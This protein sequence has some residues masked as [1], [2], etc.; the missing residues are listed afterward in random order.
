MSFLPH[1]MTREERRRRPEVQPL[2]ARDVPEISEPEPPGNLLAFQVV[3]GVRLGSYDDQTCCPRRGSRWQWRSR[4]RR[5]PKVS[6]KPCSD[7]DP[8]H[9]RTSML[10]PREYRRIFEE[11]M[12]RAAA[13]CAGLSPSR[14]RNTPVCRK[15]KG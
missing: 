1:R 7:S 14:N 10:P 4:R 3:T 12:R 15:R 9:L 13:K 11:S 6:S 5:C 8:S 2:N